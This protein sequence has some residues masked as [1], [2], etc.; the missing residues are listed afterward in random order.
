MAH[1]PKPQDPDAPRVG[2][3]A[4]L[5]FTRLLVKG[6]AVPTLVRHE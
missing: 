5:H 6:P 4:M 2:C 3:R 1:V